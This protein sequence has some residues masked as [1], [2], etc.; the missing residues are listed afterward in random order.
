MRF[1]ER[2]IILIDEHHDLP[3]MMLFQPC[4][5]KG[6]R[7]FQS[8]EIL[9]VQ[10]KQTGFDLPQDR[11]FI[12][13]QIRKHLLVFLIQFQKDLLNGLHDRSFASLCIGK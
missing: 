13:I 10:C 11:L 6:E 7:A 4:H 2:R 3:A 5:Q 12:F 1:D 9:F 8:I